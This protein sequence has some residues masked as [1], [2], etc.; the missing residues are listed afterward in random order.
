M[1]KSMTGFGKATCNFEN[2]NI[3]CEIKSLNSKQFDLFVK[4][5]AIYREKE[6]EIRNLLKEKLIRGK[7]EIA[8][9]IEQSGLFENPVINKNAFIS[10]YKQIESLQNEL[11]TEFKPADIFTLL[12]KV[13]DIFITEQV[14]IDEKEWNALFQTINEAIK[15]VDDFRTQEGKS[16][17]KDIYK[18]INN[19]LDLLKQID[20]PEK[21]RISRIKEKLR[22]NVF[23]FINKDSLDNNRFEQELFY[24]LEKIDINEEKVRLKNHCDYFLG[25]LNNSVSQGKKLGFIIQEIGREIN[26]IGSKANDKEIQII[27]VQMKDEL[28]KIK[29]QIMNI[30]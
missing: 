2:K 15:N 8:L 30:L 1:I 19:I 29:E 4:I 16:T 10:Y 12:T 23:E 11:N 14:E 3:I 18:R 7:I 17:E 26:T 21:Q 6:S 28:E 27:T 24:Y 20:K 5:P 22:N 13:P 25:T 9:Y